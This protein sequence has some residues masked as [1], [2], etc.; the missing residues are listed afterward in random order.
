[1]TAQ[2]ISITIQ[3]KKQIIPNLKFAPFDCHK[4]RQTNTKPATPKPFPTNPII[5]HTP[6]LF[7]L[8]ISKTPKKPSTSSIRT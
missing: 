4:P 7:P 5:S 2:T 3:T 1:M 8:N 6:N